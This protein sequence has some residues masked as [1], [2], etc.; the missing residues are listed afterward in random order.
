MIMIMIMI[1]TINIIIILISVA[2]SYLVL[3]KTSRNGLV[4]DSF[5]HLLFFIPEFTNKNDSKTLT[6]FSFKYHCT[7]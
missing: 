1:I 2:S 6:I 7:F 3:F 4:L 5:T